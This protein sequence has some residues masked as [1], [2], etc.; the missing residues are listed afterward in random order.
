MAY[1]HPACFQML[2]SKNWSKVS[3]GF[4]L[5]V[6]LPFLSGCLNCRWSPLVYIRIQPSSCSILI[7]SLTLY[8]FIMFLFDNTKVVIFLPFAKIYLQEIL[9]LIGMISAVNVLHRDEESADT[10]KGIR[11][12]N[13]KER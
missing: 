9:K 11:A 8:F 3:L 5:T 10:P 7:T 2:F 13:K 6:T 12:A 1:R 4:P